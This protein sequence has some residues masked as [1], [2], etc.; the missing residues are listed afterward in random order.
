VHF[1]GELNTDEISS[2]SDIENGGRN[3]IDRR[4][5]ADLYSSYI[6]FL[7]FEKDVI[8]GRKGG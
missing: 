2:L 3:K 8:K 5:L 1:S 4:R 7:F 6:S